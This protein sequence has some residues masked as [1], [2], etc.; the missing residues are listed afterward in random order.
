[1]LDLNFVRDNLELVKRKMRERGMADAMKDFE[2]L[3]ATRRTALARAEE[4]KARRN[5]VSDEI[6]GL[7]KQKQDAGAQI[8]EMKVLKQE[9]EIYDAHAEVADKQLQELL[10]GI[11][12]VPHESVPAGRGPED[13]Q[14]IRR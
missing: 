6:A 2:S 4:L 7:K 3:D 5:K 14:E 12:N 10:V 13:N 8:A 11:P 9:I 1:M